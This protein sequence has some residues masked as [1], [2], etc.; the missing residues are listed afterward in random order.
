M[1]III[2][3][4]II[5]KKP[6]T[7]WAILIELESYVLFCLLIHIVVLMDRQHY[8]EDLRMILLAG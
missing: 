2:I 7:G 5:L 1:F 8:N 4:S 3:K 6:S